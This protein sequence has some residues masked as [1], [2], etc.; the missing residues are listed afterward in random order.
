MVRAVSRPLCDAQRCSIAWEDMDGGM[1]TGG[2]WKCS[3]PP[4]LEVHSQSAIPLPGAGGG[5]GGVL[6]KGKLSFR[7]LDGTSS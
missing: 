5:G 4:I 2:D 1:Q 7:F 6:L 3:L